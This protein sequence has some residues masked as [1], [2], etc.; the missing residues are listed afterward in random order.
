MS[1]KI[2][3]TFETGIGSGS[4]SLFNEGKEIDFWEGAENVSR[5]EDLLDQISSLLKRNKV[6]PK[7]IDSIFV[8]KGPGS[9]T[10]IKIGIATAKGLQKSLNCKCFGINLL[11]AIFLSSPGGNS[12]AS[13][14]ISR[15]SNRAWLQNFRKENTGEIKPDGSFIRLTIDDLAEWFQKACTSKLLLEKILYEKVRQSGLDFD[16][17][18]LECVNKD[19]ALSKLICVEGA[20]EDDLEQILPIYY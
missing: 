9:F 13:V 15:G 12:H 3:L 17:S 11:K 2:I 16:M 14:A 10:G 6:S 4:I 18:R 8:S 19:I 20:S 7:Q 1:S 5:A